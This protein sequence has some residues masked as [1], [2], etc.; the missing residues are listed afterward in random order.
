[1][2]INKGQIIS[3]TPECDGV[4]SSVVSDLGQRVRLGT[5]MRGCWIGNI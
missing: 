4:G 2:V 1:M 5:L 3:W